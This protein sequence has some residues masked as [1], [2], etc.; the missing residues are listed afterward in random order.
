MLVVT[1]E[2]IPG[3]EIRRVIGEVIG[4]TAKTVNAYAEKLRYL[5]GTSNPDMLGVLAR[6]RQE[7]VR[8]MWEAARLNGANAVIGMRFDHRP[9]NAGWNEICAYG[10][11]VW[12]ESI[13]PVEPAGVG[14]EQI[15]A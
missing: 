10:T 7:A 13:Q 5:N 14:R 12:V 11:A 3:F 2:A 15:A 8:R 1:T 6:V 9:V 4:V